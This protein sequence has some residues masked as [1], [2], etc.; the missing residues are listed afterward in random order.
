[1]TSIAMDGPR[2]AMAVHD[3]SGRCD[4]VVFWNVTWHYLT[5]LTRFNGPTCLPTHAAGGI[6]DVAIGGS[7]AVWTVTYGGVTRLIAAGITDC[8]EWVVSRPAAAEQVT[9]LAGD[10]GVLAYALSPNANSNRMLASVGVVPDVWRGVPIQSVPVGV[11][12]LSTFA[13][14][15]AVLGRQ[16]TVSITTADGSFERRIATGR[17]RAVALRPSLV[18]ALTTRGTLEVFSRPSGGRLHSWRVPPGTRRLDVQYGTAL[19]TAA[20]DVYAMNLATGRTAR[21]F[22]APTRVA[23]EIEAPGAAIQYNVGGRGFLR[24]VA[25]SRIES[26]T[27]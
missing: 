10:G 15:V 4:Y 13:G 11:S 23:A 12:A 5:R 7:R 22:H 2:V 27:R 18:V 14:D 21:L 26:S 1:M 8:Q 25:M 9:G 16:G 24:F 6:T 19:L 20:R 17:A 3:P